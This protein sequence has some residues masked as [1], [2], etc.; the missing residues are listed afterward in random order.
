MNTIC[1]YDYD[2]YQ[3]NFG[4]IYI[5]ECLI[6]KLLYVGQTVNKIEKR[7]KKHI[8]DSNRNTDNTYFH[9]A[10]RKYGSENFKVH[11]IPLKILNRDELNRLEMEFI[12]LFNTTNRMCGYNISLGGTFN[13]SLLPEVRNKISKNNCMHVQENRVKNQSS[14]LKKAV[15]SISLTG[16][17]NFF[18][19]TCEAARYLKLSQGNIVNVLKGRNKTVKGYSFSYASTTEDMN[20]ISSV[21]ISKKILCINDGKIFETI[22]AIAKYYHINK[23]SVKNVLSGNQ[24]DTKHLIFKYVE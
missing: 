7:W 1:I 23:T 4:N 18:P 12:S 22:S 6:N 15:K 24:L 20:Y 21:S 19:S 10:L 14:Q 16:I 8:N 17:V 11:V 5:V 2:L 3:N 13:V 9:N